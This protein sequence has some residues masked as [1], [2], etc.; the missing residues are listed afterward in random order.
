[1]QDAHP[2][3][4]PERTCDCTPEAAWA[5][6]DALSDEALTGDRW[7]RKLMVRAINHALWVESRAA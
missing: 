4:E 5:W 6:V 7:A 1:M 3:I 2:T